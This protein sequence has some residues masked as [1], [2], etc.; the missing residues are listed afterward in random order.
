MSCTVDCACS[1]RDACLNPFTAHVDD[2]EDDYEK[3]QDEIEECE[4]DVGHSGVPSEDEWHSNISDLS[5]LFVIARI[6]F[7]KCVFK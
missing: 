6:M 1:S 3:T 4:R 7:M 5:I 2:D